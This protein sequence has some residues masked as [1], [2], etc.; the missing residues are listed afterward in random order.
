MPF[1]TLASK[2][3]IA[4]M[5]VILVGIAVVEITIG[6]HP[7]DMGMPDF[8]VDVLPPAATITLLSVGIMNLLAGV[9]AWFVV[10]GRA[11]ARVK[12][13]LLLILF[14]LTVVTLLICSTGAAAVLAE[15]FIATT[16]TSHFQA[17]TDALHDALL[18]SVE[19]SFKRGW[20]Q[21]DPTAYLTTSIVAACGSAV[22]MRTQ[23][24]QWQP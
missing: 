19:T 9:L 20:S 3:L 11:P 4:S 15:Q 6:V 18:Y 21:C 24:W 12:R 13:L 14:I 23:S 2:M 22:R 10:C 17:G 7:Y 16:N 8:L 5:G 1:L